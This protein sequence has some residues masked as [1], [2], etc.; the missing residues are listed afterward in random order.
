MCVGVVLG[1][2]DRGGG[3]LSR[4]FIKILFY[5]IFSGFLEVLF[6][7]ILGFKRNEESF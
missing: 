6:C 4:E 1:V 2:R 7:G 3:D 5:L